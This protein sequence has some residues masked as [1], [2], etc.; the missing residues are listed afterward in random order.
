MKKRSEWARLEKQML[1]SGMTQ[2]AWCEANG[3]N[4]ASMWKS[5][6]R[7][8]K[9]DNN[10]AATEETET[11]IKWVEVSPA[12][13]K[14]NH[15]NTVPPGIEVTTG[16]YTIRVFAGFDRMIFIDICKALSAL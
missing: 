1:S 15:T 5:V 11:G 8:K 9:S 13:S 2:K 16:R 3:I 4:P 6:N 7:R 12:I 14:D 10:I